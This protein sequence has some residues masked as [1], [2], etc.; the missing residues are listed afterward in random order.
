VSVTPDEAGVAGVLDTSEA[1]PKVVRGSAVRTAGYV[2]GLLVGL[3]ATPL[4]VRHLGAVDFGRWA[5]VSSLIFIV[6]ALTEGGLAALGLREYATS[7]LQARRDL[8]SNL[9]GL[10]VI[11]SVVAAVLAAGF[12]LVAGYTREMVIGTL[13][14]SGSLVLM[15]FAYTLG[16]DLSARLRLGWVSALDFVRQIVTSLAMILLVVLGASLLP[17]FLIPPFAAAVVLSLTVVVID[18]AVPLRPAFAR[19]AQLELLRKTAVYAAATALGVLYFQL[20]MILTSLVTSDQE[21]GFFGVS[22]RIMELANGVPWLLSTSAFPLIARAAQTD[23][24]RLRYGLGRMTDVALVA[25]TAFAIG[26]C[27]GAPFAIQVVAGDGFD[28]STDALQIMGLASPA[29]FMVATL[30]Y[31]L[32]AIDA[33]RRMLISNAVAVAVMLIA[34]P[35]LAHAHGAVGGA[36]AAVATE[37][38]LVVAYSIALARERAELRLNL[39]HLPRI[40]LA[41]AIAVA[42]ALILSLPAVVEALGALAIFG[43]LALALHTI[44]DE[45]FDVLPRRLRPRR[46]R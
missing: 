4:V 24:Q 20:A 12:A 28:R 35:L 17:F 32:L 45:A 29:T 40:L 26:I 10:R 41:A 8:I 14:L 39:A 5:T 38:V 3:L 23:A 18:R 1:G 34:T 9:L 33:Q 44:P 7:D 21:T 46:L 42:P 2:G 27:V 6:T 19:A 36:I 15:S 31:A 11:L 16:I 13:L 22:F 25:G 37:W 30:A 43:V